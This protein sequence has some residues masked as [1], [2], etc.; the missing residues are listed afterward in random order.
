M[1][2]L[3][4]IVLILCTSSVIADDCRR[5]SN[6]LILFDASGYMREK[7][8][9][10]LFLQQMGFFEKAMPVTAD[11][12]FNVGIRHYGL[13]VGM[14]C[15]NTESILAIRPWDPERFL[16]S[17]PR[18]ISYGV[19]ALSAGLRAAAEE[20]SAAQ[21]KSIIILI[22]GGI[23]SCKVD[24]VKTAEQIALNNPDLEIHTFQVGADPEGRYYL[25]GIAQKARGSF[26]QSDSFQSPAPWYAWMK[27]YLVTPCAP[28]APTPARPQV[29]GTIAPVTFDYKSFSVKSQD[30][31]ADSQ[32]TASLTA[33]A[34][35]LQQDPTIRVVLHGYSDGR[36]SQEYNL[37]L[38]QQRA[39]AVARFLMKSYK[40]PASRIS[41]NAHGMS[42]AALQGP[43]AMDDRMARR[44]E[45]EFVR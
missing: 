17:F 44:V 39:E 36:G 38:S 34:K 15:E 14:G 5:V 1:A 2:F 32:N 24:P 21:G 30:P 13:K 25:S 42:Q 28:A 6:I 33:V 23:E 37:K 11:G 10:T 22:G 4:L 31:Q 29:G 3:T 16:N 8:R 19:S 7:D 9:Y 18:S 20:A 40:I 45:F 26:N 27:K 12:F 43:S 35:A 41:I